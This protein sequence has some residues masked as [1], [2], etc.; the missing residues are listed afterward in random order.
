MSLLRTRAARFRRFTR[1]ARVRLAAEARYEVR[2]AL[3]LEPL[4][5]IGRAVRGAWLVSDPHWADRLQSEMADMSAERHAEVE[6]RRVAA[7][8][9]L[10]QRGGQASY[11]GELRVRVAGRGVRLDEHPQCPSLDG[12]LTDELGL[13]DYGGDHARV[14]ITVELLDADEP[15]QRPDATSPSAAAP[16]RATSTDI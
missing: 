3:G 13:D 9:R 15:Q 16:E 8:A 7:R 5:R 14:R 6:R 12:W 10:A 4:R 2:S 1:L 11:V